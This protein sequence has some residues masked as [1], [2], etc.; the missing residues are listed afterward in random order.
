MCECKRADRC[1]DPDIERKVR[2]A[3]QIL[4]ERD[5]C[6]L[7]NDVNE[8]SITHKL[9]GYL[10]SLFPEWEVDC[11]YNRNHDHV[12]RLR[13]LVREVHTDEPEG[14]TVFPDIIVH[15]RNSDEN[16]LVIE[17]KKASNPDNGDADF[18][19]LRAFLQELHYEH[20]LFLR[21]RGSAEDRHALTWFHTEGRAGTNR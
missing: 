12:K 11:E 10:E 16:L 19:K 1:S 9:A 6:L 20:G 21:L 14:K 2:S 7:E 17:V 3:L 18:R 8:R 13:E 5:G 15:H 4:D